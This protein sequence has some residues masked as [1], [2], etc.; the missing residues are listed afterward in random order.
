M[1]KSHI[2]SIPVC[3][4]LVI[5]NSPGYKLVLPSNNIP[6]FHLFINTSCLA[7]P[8]G[9]RRNMCRCFYHMVFSKLMKPF[10]V[11]WGLARHNVHAATSEK[12]KGGPQLPTEEELFSLCRFW[13]MALLVPRYWDCLKISQA[14]SPL[15]MYQL[16]SQKYSLLQALNLKAGGLITLLIVRK[17]PVT[18]LFWVDSY[19]HYNFLYESHAQQ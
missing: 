3:S 1:Q 13:L 17:S 5:C 11:K 19:V 2:P 16:C 8:E 15:W 18:E 12:M 7:V 4:C 6:W 14:V 9:I 10:H